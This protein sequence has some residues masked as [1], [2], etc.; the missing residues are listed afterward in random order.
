MPRQRRTICR[1]DPNNERIIT[2][3]MDKW[4]RYGRV[5]RSPFVEL[6][7]IIPHSPRQICHSWW[8]KLDPRLCLTIHVPFTHREKEYIYEWVEEYLSFNNN[9]K[10][11]WKTLQSNMEKK[12]FDI[13]MDDKVLCDTREPEVSSNIEEFGENDTKEFKG[14]GTD[15][16]SRIEEFE[17]FNAEEY[18]ARKLI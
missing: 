18:K 9:K 5:N 2:L 16:S 15:E 8:N 1:I 11:P 13:A 4:S 3:Y 12:S 10:I 17:G 7:K 6:S 14:S